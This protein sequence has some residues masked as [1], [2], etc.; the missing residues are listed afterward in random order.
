MTQPRINESDLRSE[1]DSQ[2]SLE[3]QHTLPLKNFV[4]LQMTI[5]TGYADPFTHMKLYLKLMEVKGASKNAMCKFFP[6]NL[7]GLEQIWYEKLR[8][9]SI[10]SFPQM[11]KKLASR[12]RGPRKLKG[13]LTCF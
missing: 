3:I 1:M 5:Y 4:M 10:H 2:F 13:N 12:L 11:S 6:P 9:G 8:R 7:V